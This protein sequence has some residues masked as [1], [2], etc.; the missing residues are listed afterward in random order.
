MPRAVRT[1][2]HRAQQ[3]VGRGVG[4][5]GAL[6]VTAG[7]PKGD[8]RHHGTLPGVALPGVLGGHL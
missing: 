6:L 7:G 5:H 3:Q 2:T 4:Q 1:H 8:R